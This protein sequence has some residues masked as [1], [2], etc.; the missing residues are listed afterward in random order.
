MTPGF[1]AALACKRVPRS[2][3]SCMR[4]EQNVGDR[5]G[6]RCIQSLI[7]CDFFRYGKA[8]GQSSPSCAGIVKG[9]VFYPRAGA[10]VCLSTLHEAF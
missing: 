7:A 5:D 4:I 9:L 1:G 6:R 3:P 10:V 2:L 8:P